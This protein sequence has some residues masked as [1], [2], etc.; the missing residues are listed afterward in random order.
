[1]NV[2][3]LVW[4][5]L[6]HRIA[7]GTRT[8]G[9]PLHIFNGRDALWDAYEE[10]LDLALY[11][12]QAIAEREVRMKHGRE[13]YDRIQDPEDKIP[14]DEPVF[15]LRAQDLCAPAAV[16]AWANLVEVALAAPQVV[17]A[18]RSQAAEMRRWQ[19][20]HHGTKLPDLPGQ[21]A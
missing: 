6:Q 9:E 13:D 18:A 21:P 17:E 7:T 2:V 10:A 11:L 4:I 16:E 12:R 15:L 1:M 14:A 19:R 8:Y 20:E 5:D 3:D